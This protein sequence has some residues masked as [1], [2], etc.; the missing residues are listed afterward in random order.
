MIIFLVF[1]T[2]GLLI[3]KL[4]SMND[5]VMSRCTHLILDEIHERDIN[6]DILLLAV[7]RLLVINKNLK[8]LIMSA[9]LDAEKF[10][11]Y[12]SES[13]E[14]EVGQAIKIETDTNFPVASYNLEDVVGTLKKNKYFPGYMTSTTRQF[15]EKELSGEEALADS[16]PIEIISGMTKYLHENKPFGSILCFLPGWEDIVAA[17]NEIEQIL[18]N[19]SKRFKLYCIHSSTP[20]EVTQSIFQN[21]EG[22]RKI[23]L[24]TNIAESSITIPDVAYVVDSGK[25]KINMY[26]PALRVNSLK[27]TWISKSNSIQR[28]GRVGRTQPGEYYLLCSRT[29]SLSPYLPPE[30]LRVGLEDVCLSVKGLGFEGKCS[31]IFEELLDKPNK[32]A[33]RDAVNR[34]IR[35]DAL[36]PESENIT[37][38]GRILST[39]PLN[40]SKN[41]VH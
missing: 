16:V 35:L 20:P 39:I 3:K 5:D 13:G 18:G 4:Q 8:V 14:L 23:I 38:L 1:C 2:S 22:E 37:E 7:R 9:T 33:L 12:F 21:T 15:I 11:N 34:L 32:I 41:N 30:I 19:S 6:T 29:R 25:Q 17:R 10:H 31:V 26:N 24:A 36:E 40:P 27:T 28:L